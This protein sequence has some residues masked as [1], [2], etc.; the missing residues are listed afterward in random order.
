MAGLL[1]ALSFVR[2]F[3]G[4]VDVGA[5]QEAP[6]A[7]PA[8]PRRARTSTRGPALF[9]VGVFHGGGDIVAVEEGT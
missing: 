4:A 6:E 2:A 8:P 7:E 1:P 9:L 5:S 3:H